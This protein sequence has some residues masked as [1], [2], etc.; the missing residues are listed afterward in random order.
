M[1]RGFERGADFV[2]C[3]PRFLELPTRV[4]IRLVHVMP[5]LRIATGAEC[6]YRERTHLW[7]KL[8]HADVSST[9]NAVATFLSTGGHSVNREHCAIVTIHA[10]H[11]ETRPGILKLF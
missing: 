2:E 9:R 1:V 7:S 11:C 8:D 3:E 5:A 6:V 10:A 4:E